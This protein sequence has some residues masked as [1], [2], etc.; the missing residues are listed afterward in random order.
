[1]IVDPLALLLGMLGCLNLALE[2]IIKIFDESQNIFW[3]VMFALSIPGLIWS[4][5]DLGR[6]AFISWL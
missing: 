6:A 4:A 3:R 5:F 2:F 1:M